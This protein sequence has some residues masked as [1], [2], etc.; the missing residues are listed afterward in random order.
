MRGA[1]IT[2]E[3]TEGVGKSTCLDYV[4][5]SL[6]AADT[7]VAVTRE[8]GGTPLGE[9]IREWILQGDHAVLSAETETLLM[10]AARAYHLDEIIRPA[11][12]SGNW[13]VC[14]RFSDAT[15]AY[16][17]GGRGASAAW[18][19]SLRAAVHADL[20]PDL[21]LLLDAPVDVGLDRISGRDPDHFERESSGFFARVR[22]AYLQLA[23]THP[24]RI[25]LV[26]ATRTLPEVKR[27]I[28]AH[29]EAFLRQFSPVS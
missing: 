25:K 26:D 8:P 21:T 28:G 20:E 17:G 24:D 3:G 13:V 10:F 4:V 11:L 19:A 23:R 5:E 1:F 27:Q 9:S 29:L 6:A 16:Q 18:I 15:A 12:A 7:P 14:D 22:E 2:L